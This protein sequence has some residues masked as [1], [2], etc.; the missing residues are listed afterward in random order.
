MRGR[1]RGAPPFVWLGL[2]P[3]FIYLVANVISFY[4][5]AERLVGGDLNDFLDEHIIDGAGDLLVSLV[6]LALVVALAYAMHR[7]KVYLKV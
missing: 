7:R 4:T 1:R 6:G 2:N 3:S 5:L